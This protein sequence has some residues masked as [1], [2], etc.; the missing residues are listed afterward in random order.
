MQYR[1][2]AGGDLHKRM[3]DLT[4]IRNYV[5]VSR[6]VQLEIME[7]ISRLGITHFISLGDWF[8]NGYGSD[9]S[10]A[11]AHT[12]TD[13]MMSD[14]LKG[15]FYGLIGNH[16]KIRLD[17]NPELFLIQPHPYYKSRHK[18]DRAEQIIKTP[19]RL[20][21]NNVQFHFLHWNK[22]AED[23]S[24]YKACIDK[25]IR[26]NIGLYHSEYVIPSNKLEGLNMYY[27]QS[28]SK[29]S[30]IF[31]DID[32]AIVGHIH[33]PLGTFN[34]QRN[35]GGVTT[36]IVPG[37]LT[38]TDAGSGSRH[39]YV[40]LPIIDIDEDGGIALS[41]YRQY[42]HT[43]KLE[44]MPKNL[45]DEQ[46]EKLKSLRGNTKETLYEELEQ[47]TFVGESSG[48]LTLNNFMLKQGYNDVD[49]K[50]IRNVIDNPDDINNLVDIYKGKNLAE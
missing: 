7:A 28:N 30:A 42:L 45:N 19:D 33:K 1:V 3:K 31:E 2:M 17:S 40:D 34:I 6:L 12:D 5:D 22:D 23:C 16:I 50:L 48:F 11:L 49:K 36:M 44:F 27:T 29:L 8:S 18:V 43:D 10:A 13:K 47:T 24:A 4:T 35:D 9:V 37:S 38:N 32:I 21:L 14:L 26:Y 39:D 46:K 41:Y 25:S 20:T 15:N